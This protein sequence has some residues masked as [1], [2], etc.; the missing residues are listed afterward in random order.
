MAAIVGTLL[1]L[2]NHGDA[3]VAG[4]MGPARWIKLGVTYLVPFSVS[5]VS[6]VLTLSRLHATGQSP[7]R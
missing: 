6:S 1:G 3:I 2:I 4:T 5:L 7:P